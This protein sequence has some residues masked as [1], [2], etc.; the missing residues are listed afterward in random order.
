ML[1]RLLEAIVLVELL[2]AV[3]K[4]VDEQRPDTGVLR[5]ATARPTASCS[6]AT[7]QA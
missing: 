6:N 2:G 3:V 5:N 7:P 1:R 4:G